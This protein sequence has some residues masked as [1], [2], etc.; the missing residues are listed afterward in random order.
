M[1][2]DAHVQPNW[3]K[4]KTARS[5]VRQFMDFGPD[6]GTDARGSHLGESQGEWAVS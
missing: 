6:P 1:G 4:A 3:V 5:L 2:R